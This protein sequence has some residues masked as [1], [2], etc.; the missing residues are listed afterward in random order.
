MIK[1]FRH[2]GNLLALAL[3]SSACVSYRV[4]DFPLLI[5]LPASRECFEVKVVSGDEK[6]YDEKTCDAMI[7]RGIV[8]TSAAWKL[9]RGDIQSNCQVAECTQ[10]QG[11]ADGLFLTVDKVLQK[12]PINE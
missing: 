12:L 1:L 3:I 5:R 7:A 8:L 4:S 2:F 9:I 11:A 6:R 10:I